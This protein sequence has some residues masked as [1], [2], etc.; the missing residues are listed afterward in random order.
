MALSP[1]DDTLTSA[2]PATTSADATQCVA[3]LVHRCH[4]YWQAGPVGYQAF[5][6][7]ERGH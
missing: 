7:A 6:V 4:G 1:H 3:R 5:P 2:N